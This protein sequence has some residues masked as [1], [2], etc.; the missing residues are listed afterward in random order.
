VGKIFFCFAKTI[1][2]NKHE[3]QT[4]QHL[5]KNI[6]FSQPRQS[7]QPQESSFKINLGISHF[8]A[9]CNV[10]GEFQLLY[11]SYVQPKLFTEPKI[12]PLS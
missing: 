9:G 5:S 7:S 12:M 6:Q 4:C 2:H 1:V 10:P 3:K 11:N 8:A